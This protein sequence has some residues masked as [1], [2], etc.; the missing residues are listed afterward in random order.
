VTAS[1]A[2]PSDLGPPGDFAS[3]SITI[4]GSWKYSSPIAR[5]SQ[6]GAG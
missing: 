6:A 1:S 3:P 2:S 4:S 5:R